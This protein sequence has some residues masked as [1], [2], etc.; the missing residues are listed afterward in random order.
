MRN[1]YKDEFLKKYGVKLGFM[2]PFVKA[3]CFALQDQ[4]VVNAGEST[5]QTTYGSDLTT[6]L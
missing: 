5:I 1:K 3:S 4:P 6:L 2:S